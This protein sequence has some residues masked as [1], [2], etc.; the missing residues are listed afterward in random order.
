MSDTTERNLKVIEQKATETPVETKSEQRHQ[1][2]PIVK[3]LLNFHNENNKNF[4]V[5]DLFKSR[6]L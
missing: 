6:T 4:S 2:N 3:K 5:K 1:T